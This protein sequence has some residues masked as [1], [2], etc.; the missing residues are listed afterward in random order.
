MN[1]TCV[2]RYDAHLQEWQLA[3]IWSFIVSI[4]CIG[5]LLGTLVA[6]PLIAR[7]GRWVRAAGRC[8][9]GLGLVRLGWASAPALGRSL[10]RKRSFLLNN[11][12]TI[13]GAA[14]MLLSTTA[15]SFEMIM[16]ARFIYGIS[17][18][19]AEGAASAFLLCP[20]SPP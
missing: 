5:G 7:F 9:A 3:L 16:A 2:R 17:A 13:A 8:W 11:C 20:V 4:F 6:S 19:E 1:Q 12:V 10:F 15:E 14:L 18:G